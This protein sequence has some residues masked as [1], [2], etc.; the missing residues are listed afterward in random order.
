[1]TEPVVRDP[2]RDLERR[3]GRR[4]PAWTGRIDFAAVRKVMDDIGDGGWV[5]I[6]GALPKGQPLIESHT[7]NVRFMRTPLLVSACHRRIA[8]PTRAVWAD[9]FPE[10]EIP[11]PPP[12]AAPEIPHFA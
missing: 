1:V 5:Q 12:D 11:A 6:E 7:D 8:S 9:V 3:E 4:F 2:G 10:L